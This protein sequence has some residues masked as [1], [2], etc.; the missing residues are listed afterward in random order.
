[1]DIGRALYYRIISA[2]G[3]PSLFSPAQRDGAT[4]FILHRFQDP[5]RGIAGFDPAQLQR[6]LEYLRKNKYEI[7]SLE[8]IFD[9]L[10]RKGPPPDEPAHAA[11]ARGRRDCVVAVADG[12]GRLPGSGRLDAIGAA[13]V[14]AY[15]FAAHGARCV[16]QHNSLAIIRNE[17]PCARPRLN[18]SQSSAFKCT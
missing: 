10:A 11:T 17:W 18:I 15:G 8:N 4:I 5:K 3:V 13:R 9:H 12:L 6:G 7:V 16:P 14:V 1:M 2:P